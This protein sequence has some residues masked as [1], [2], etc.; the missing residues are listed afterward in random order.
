V[1][2]LV[3][4][5]RGGALGE[6]V[7]EDFDFIRHVVLLGRHSLLDGGGSEAFWRPVAHQLYYLAL[8]PTIVAR[9]ALVSGLHATLLALAAVLLYR[10]VRPGWSGARAAAA[11]SFPF[12]IESVRTVVSWPSHFVELG[13]LLFAVLALHEASRRRMASALAALLLALLCKEVAVVA[14]VMI[15]LLPDA[16]RTRRERVR[17]GIGSGVVTAAWALAYL[18]IRRAAHL[19]LPHDLESNPLVLSTPMWMRFAWAGSNC[20][21]AMA[22]L[23]AIPVPRQAAIGLAIAGI[24]IAA[25]VLFGVNDPARRR[26]VNARPWVAWGLIWFALATATLMAIFPIWAPNRSLFGSV[27]FGIALAAM[28]DAAHPALLASLVAV[29]VAAFVVAPGASAQ[30]TV[31]PPETG[32]FMD[33]E[34]LSRLQRLMRETRRAL[35]ARYPVLPHGAGIG[36]NN[37]PRGAEYA[38]GGDHALQVWYADTTLRW[39]RHEA[40]AADTTIPI[41]TVVQFQ[42]LHEPPIVL[43]DTAAERAMVRGLAHLEAARW[44]AGEAALREAESTLTEPRAIVFRATIH[45]LRATAAD[46]REDHAGAV[47]EA[48]LALALAPEL[49]EPRIVLAGDALGRND[50]LAAIGQ[51]DTIASLVPDDP[52]LPELRRRIQAMR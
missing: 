41:L 21:R 42:V 48:R 3:A 4:R 16:S 17:W 15:P 49:L 7:A 44:D 36:Y 22:S 1:V 37:L 38:Y 33:F 24:L 35:H 29:R 39:V 45:S 43:L 18:A 14:A 28:L 40:Y 10:T 26:A 34:H 2:P 30:L 32:A 11:A 25:L 31:G 52:R 13:S 5:C 27:G 50:R 20:L 23:P 9:P 19:H 8:G 51:A 46:H 6:P 47:R 12:L